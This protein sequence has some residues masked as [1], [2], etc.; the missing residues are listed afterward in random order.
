[1]RVDFVD[2]P[3]GQPSAFSIDLPEAIADIDITTAQCPPGAR[4]PF[5]QDW[6]ITPGPNSV[7]GTYVIAVVA[8][9]RGQLSGRSLTLTVSAKPAPATP[10]ARAVDHSSGAVAEPE[11]N[12]KL[13]H[14]LL[15]T[16]DGR[17]WGQG[18]NEFGQVR[19]GYRRP[20]LVFG[21]ESEQLVQPE[22]IL[23]PVAVGPAE[24][25]WRSL[26]AVWHGFG[27]ASFALRDDGAGQGSV[28]WW[29]Y[30]SG[31]DIWQSGPA[32]L[33][34]ARDDI[35]AISAIDLAQWLALDSAGRVYGG[36][37]P[38]PV[39][40]TDSDSPVTGVEA[41]T[42]GAERPFADVTA[43]S[44]EAGHGF[45]LRAGRVSKVYACRPTGAREGRLYAADL[46]GAGWRDIV[47][48]AAGR[49]HL[50]ALRAD[51]VVLAGGENEGGQLGTAS[52]QNAPFTRVG[53]CEESRYTNEPVQVVGLGAA[54]AIAAKKDRSFALLADGT[55]SVWGG[56]RLSPAQVE[57]LDTVL[58][59]GPGHA[60]RNDC[61]VGGTLW[62]ICDS[63]PPRAVRVQGVGEDPAAGCTLPDFE[64]PEGTVTLDLASSRG[65]ASYILTVTRNGHTDAIDLVLRGCPGGVTC[66][67]EPDPIPVG[68][69]ASTI[70]FRTGAPGAVV[71]EY[72]VTVE[73][74]GGG[75][76]REKI[77][78]LRI[79]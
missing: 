1:M 11:L 51:G 7:P 58:A 48:I 57:G 10:A 9:V 24:W 63:S 36:G 19:T 22:L 73:T 77:I 53:L 27:A 15:L 71:G 32:R 23:E 49:R 20:R 14:A 3:A 26:A 45:L 25:R 6:T 18:G 68:Q 70:S 72:S 47:A 61:P 42:G 39:L 69:N 8:S 62:V 56:G 50:L 52:T 40:V 55:V 37:A 54:I 65:E 41:I 38:A 78:T 13:G 2:Q 31:H 74:R 79:Q 76:T 4:T 75:V 64:L 60:I 67:A 66:A 29:G 43:T 12:I 17:L 35:V 5:C 59:I 46:A 44:A 30:D 21:E 16:S 33:L 28:W 34:G